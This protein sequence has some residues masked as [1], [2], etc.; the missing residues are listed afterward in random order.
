MK[1]RTPPPYQGVF[2]KPGMLVRTPGGNV[3]DVAAYKQAGVG[4]L[5][6]NA[7]HTDWYTVRTRCLQ[8]QMPCGNWFHCRSRAELQGLLTSSY[9][10]VGV[11]VEAELETTLTPAVIADLIDA[12]GYTGEISLQVY[13]WLQNS[14]DMTPLADYAVMLEMFPADAPALFDA[15]TQTVKWTDCETHARQ[16]GVK[17]PQCLMQAYQREPLG[18]G[19]RSW[20]DSAPAP[21]H[22]YCLDDATGESPDQVEDWC[23]P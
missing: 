13:G 9:P 6:L 12:S 16:L 4:W 8:Q 11:N 10:I 22:L 5:L 21:R 17:H 15:A 1:P 20:Y 19:R 14:V 23:A 2:A 7:E 3:E 18:W